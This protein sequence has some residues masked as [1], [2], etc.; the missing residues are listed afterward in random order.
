M[1]DSL[2]QRAESGALWS[3]I[4]AI[5]ARLV[6]FIIGV[7]LA[8]LLLPEQFGLIGMLAIFMAIAQTFL[9][10]GFG[11]ALIQKK[12]VTK[13]DASSVFYFNLFIGILLAGLLY[14]SG[15]HIALFYGQPILKPLV[16]G[17]SLVI[18]INSFGIVQTALLT[19]NLDFKTQTKISLIAGSCSG[20][21]GITLAYKGFGVW[22]LV[23]QQVSFALFRSIL[24]WLLNTWRPAWVFSLQSLRQMFS[25]GSRLLISGLLNQ[26]F[27]NIYYVVIGKVFTPAALGFYTRAKRLQELPSLTLSGIVSRVS[28]PVFSSV[29]DE[30]ERL[31]KGL[32]KALVMLVFIN[33]P[34]MVGL[35]VVAEP[36]V[37]VLLT[38]KWLPCVPYL[39]LLSVIGLLLPLQMLNL[40]V[41]M[42]MGRSDLFLRLE[43]IKKVLIICN[44]A[45]TWRWGVIAMIQG[46]IVVSIASYFLNSFYTGKLINY[47]ML[48]Q[49]KNILPYFILAA[50]M[51]I[52]IYFLQYISFSGAL[53]LVVVQIAAG[54]FVYLSLCGLFRLQAFK[55]SWRMFS[56]RL[57]FLSRS[58]A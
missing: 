14:F 50:L 17:M 21:I 6:Q 18:L 19:R 46:Q 25:F 31:K 4:D 34:A 24:L 36:L 22:S 9:I 32:R 27:D 43:I 41:L 44:I 30:P 10:S 54:A 52:S 26:I 58:A 16:R 29:K 56:E 13:E 1:T 38:E 49:V 11:S 39:Q 8:R 57:P 37:K 23:I 15:H 48:E 51:G 5:G 12:E 33:S 47:S 53:S 2:R 42:A 40:N 28:F 3:F 20:A 7:I 55:D 45:L 35:A